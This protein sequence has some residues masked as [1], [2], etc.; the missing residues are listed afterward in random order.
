M[1]KQTLH[2]PYVV[3]VCWGHFSLPCWF[4]LFIIFCWKYWC[5]STISWSLLFSL[6]HLRS[7]IIQTFWPLSAR[8]LVAY[9]ATTSLS[10]RLCAVKHFHMVTFFSLFKTLH[11]VILSSQGFSF[12][13]GNIWTWNHWTIWCWTICLSWDWTSWVTGKPISIY[14]A[15]RCVCNA[16]VCPHRGSVCN[17]VVCPHRGSSAAGGWSGA[18]AGWHPQA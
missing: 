9:W 17:A 11:L 14:W 10:H 6:Y 2:L 4:N 5:H 12:L 7:S 18:R 15:L 16:V 8:N 13:L 3:S 1:V